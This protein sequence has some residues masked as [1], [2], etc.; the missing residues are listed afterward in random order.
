MGGGNL[1]TAESVRHISMVIAKR[2]VSQTFV[3]A[4]SLDFLREFAHLFL[5]N[6]DLGGNPDLFG[7]FKRRADVAVLGFGL[8]S[9]RGAFTGL[10]SLK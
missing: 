6:F 3:V 4:P 5:Q 1:G 2:H 7:R 10:E 8:G 9:P